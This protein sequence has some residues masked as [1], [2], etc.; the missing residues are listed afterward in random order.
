M[1]PTWFMV[2]KWPRLFAGDT[3]LHRLL[4]EKEKKKK[5]ED[6]GKQNSRLIKGHR[7]GNNGNAH[8]GNEPSR[9][10]GSKRRPA[11]TGGLEQGA[12][13]ENDS[14]GK[15]GV[16]PT[17]PVAQGMREENVAQEGAE[18]VDARD[19]AFRAGL[20]VVQ[21]LDP[22]RVHKN[23][24]ENTD[25]V[26]GA[27]QLSWSRS[28]ES[29]GRGVGRIICVAMCDCGMNRFRPTHPQTD[30]PTPK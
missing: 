10:H 3:S 25:M 14:T 29:L 13:D 27:S 2:T 19:N 7:G 4:E 28:A 15:R 24:R 1:K 6:A 5:E 26:S 21:H 22:S 23:G 16:A 12:K 8:A 18:V 17:Q 9:N 20:G 30:A 11:M